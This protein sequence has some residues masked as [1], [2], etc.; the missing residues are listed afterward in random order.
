MAMSL[1]GQ[2]GRSGRRRRKSLNAEINVT[3]FVDVMLVLLI[4]FMITAPLLATGIDVALPDAKAK[5][6]SQS[7]EDALTLTIN[8]EGGVFLQEEELRIEELLPKLRAIVETGYREKIFIRGDEELLYGDGVR[9]IAIAQQ[10]GFNVVAIQT[11]PNA[12]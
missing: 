2:G 5:P 3:P 12:S 11:D 7:D 1:N 4:V 10:A 6:L 8:S 9:V